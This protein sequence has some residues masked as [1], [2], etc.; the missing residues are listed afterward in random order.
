M[1][2][3]FSSGATLRPRRSRSTALTG[4]LLISTLIVAPWFA[5]QNPHDIGAFSL[6]DA[7]LAPLTAGSDGSLHVLGTDAQGRDLLSAILYGMRLS[8]QIGILSTALALFLGCTVGLVAANRRGW[9]ERLLMRLVDLLLAFPTVFLA[10]ITVAVLGSG[11]WQMI[12]A[13]VAAQ[14]PYFARVAFGTAIVETGKG[15]IEAVRAIPL[16]EWRVLYRHLLPNCLPPLLVVGVAQ[17]AHAI[18]VEA[19]LSFLGLGLSDAEPSLGVLIANGFQY[20]LSGRSWI[21]LFPGLALLALVTGI[22]LFGERL[23][24]DLG[25]RGSI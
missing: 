23:G 12:A 10:L 8:L 6:R 17:C 1:S 11:R 9:T 14:T 3:T 7:R 20:M 24:H 2:T 4:V 13:L 25:A 19:T 21:T 18:S 5:P 22:N 16:P 15:Y